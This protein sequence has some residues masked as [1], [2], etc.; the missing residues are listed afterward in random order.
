M[1]A[2]ALRL[3]I[4]V[5]NKLLYSI[6]NQVVIVPLFIVRRHRQMNI[7]QIPLALNRPKRVHGAV[8]LRHD[9]R[10]GLVGQADREAGEVQEAVDVERPVGQLVELLHH[11]RRRREAD[12][13]EGPALRVRGQG[14]VLAG[15]GGDVVDAD[16]VGGPAREQRL[17]RD[18]EEWP[19]QR[20]LGRLRVALGVL[21]AVPDEPAA[22]RVAQHQVVDVVG[23][24][25]VWVGGG[26]L[27][28]GFKV[29]LPGGDVVE[30]LSPPERP[31]WERFQ[32]D[33]CHHPEVVP[34]A[35]E[36]LPEILVLVRVGVYDV[37]V[38]Q[39][40]LEALCH[41]TNEA[42]SGR[43][44]GSAAGEYCASNPHARNPSSKG[45]EVVGVKLLR[46][47]I[48]RLPRADTYGLVIR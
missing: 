27:G 8:P 39:H 26:E 19:E 15:D 31:L 45:T 13:G 23:V 42:V 35:S 44:E 29:L 3:L 7:D 32:R 43:E 48:P 47:L 24:W 22:G 21:E 5:F 2:Q 6:L 37:S 11:L 17:L 25:V 46:H 18:V 1:H 38:S 36:C 16:G 30:C 34:P 33:G 28:V 9:A 12:G 10:D 41:V 14:R 4:G 20:R 40:D